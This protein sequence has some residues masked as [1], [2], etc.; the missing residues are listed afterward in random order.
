M[1]YSKLKNQQ[2]NEKHVKQ[3]NRNPVLIYTLL[4]EDW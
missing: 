1:V 2:T 4:I 3:N